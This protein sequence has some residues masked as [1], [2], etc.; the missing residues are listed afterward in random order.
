M[1]GSSAGWRFSYQGQHPAPDT[2]P[3][4]NRLRRVVF[5][6]VLLEVRGGQ[7]KPA[8]EEARATTD[9]ASAVPTARHAD[10]RH[11]LVLVWVRG[12]GQP[13]RIWLPMK[14]PVRNE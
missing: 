6:G 1:A 11:Q 3:M 8:D 7:R 12:D 5:A 4:R 13:E 10:F 9:R 2:I 14:V